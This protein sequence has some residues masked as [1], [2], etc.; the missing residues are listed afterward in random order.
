[1]GQIIDIV[2]NHMG[3]MGSDN[4]W[5]LDVLENGRSS[6]YADFFDIDWQPAKSELRRQTAGAVLGEPYGK[7]LE[8]GNLVLIADTTSGSFI[9]RYYGSS[10]SP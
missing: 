2:P 1:M 3:V 10:F 9:I 7:A 4:L 6:A 5:W 8:Q